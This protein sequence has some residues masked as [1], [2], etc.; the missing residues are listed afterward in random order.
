MKEQAILDIEFVLENEMEVLF[1]RYAE[2]LL[3]H[4]EL[5]V[6][7]DEIPIV[8][9]RLEKMHSMTLVKIDNIL[10]KR[11]GLVLR[12]IYSNMNASE[13]RSSAEHLIKSQSSKDEIIQFTAKQSYMIKIIIKKNDLIDKERFLRMCADYKSTHGNKALSANL[14]QYMRR[15]KRTNI[16]FIKL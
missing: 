11:F 6:A 12:T 5:F 13:K 9:E 4:L 10:Q 14:R 8:K 15:T 2:E 7:S 1:K 3:E 16:S